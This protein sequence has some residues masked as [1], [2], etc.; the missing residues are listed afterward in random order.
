VVDTRLSVMNRTLASRTSLGLMRP[1]ECK[2]IRQ[3]T[4]LRKYR[5]YR[6]LYKRPPGPELEWCSTYIRM[7]DDLMSELLPK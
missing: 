4:L 5:Q 6:T 3:S 1:E 2:P 7:M